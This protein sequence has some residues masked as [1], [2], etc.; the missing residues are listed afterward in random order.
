MAQRKPDEGIVQI[1]QNFARVH[2]VTD[3]QMTDLL[4]TEAA[5]K[6]A[7]DRGHTPTSRNLT[8]T[9]EVILDSLHRTFAEFVANPSLE[10]LQG[11]HITAQSLYRNHTRKETP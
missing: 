4:Q 6:E 5:R 10:N 2:G 7:S 1:L 3:E 9:E 8:T 11:L